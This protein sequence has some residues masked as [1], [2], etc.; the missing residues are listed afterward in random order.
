VD[1]GNRVLYLILVPPFDVMFKQQP[2]RRPPGRVTPEPV[3]RN[4]SVLSMGLHFPALPLDLVHPPFKDLGHHQNG[5]ARDLRTFIVHHVHDKKWRK[6]LLL[7]DILIEMDI[8]M[9]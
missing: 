5:V 1:G 6:N 7:D 2:K 8:I 9:K 4:K 3:L